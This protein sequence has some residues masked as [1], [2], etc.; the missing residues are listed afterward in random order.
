MLSTEKIISV[1]TLN[2]MEKSGGLE[3]DCLLSAL[4]NTVSEDPNKLRVFAT[5][6]L[7]SVETVHVGE[8][9]LK[10]YSKY[11]FY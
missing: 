7:Q 11:S 10:E 6:L 4:F 2:V 5:V 1:D 8:V 9:I 3:T